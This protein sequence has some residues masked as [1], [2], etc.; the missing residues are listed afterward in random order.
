MH[1]PA[2]PV[3]RCRPPSSCAWMGG[4]RCRSMATRASRSATGCWPSSRA[5]RRPSC[6]PQTWQRAAWVGHCCP[7]RAVEAGP[8]SDPLRA[9]LPTP[10]MSPSRQRPTLQRRRRTLLPLPPLQRSCSR[11]PR[12]APT[13]CLPSLLLQGLPWHSL[14]CWRAWCCGRAAAISRS[15]LACRQRWQACRAAVAAVLLPIAAQAPVTSGSMS[16][17]PACSLAT[18]G[19]L[20]KSRAAMRV[21]ASNAALL[22]QRC[23]RCSTE[24]VWCLPWSAVLEAAALHLAWQ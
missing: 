2:K 10:C 15:G 18:P 4:R 21:A 6:W 16:G 11:A 3:M 8:L 1:A 5:P 12:L 13:S 24:V 20:S 23:R 9:C 19:M 22:D 14:R 17:C 7:P